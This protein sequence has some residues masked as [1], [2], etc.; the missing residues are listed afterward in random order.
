MAEKSI[1]QILR[2]CDQ[3]FH[4]HFRKESFTRK[5]W[6]SLKVETWKFTKNK[7]KASQFNASRLSIC[8]L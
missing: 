2:L 5:W 1:L 8:R 4:K 7:L 6:L 3:D